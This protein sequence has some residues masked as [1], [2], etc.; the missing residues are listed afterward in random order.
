MLLAVRLCHRCEL[1]SNVLARVRV[2]THGR[3]TPFVSH[4]FHYLF[5]H[6]FRFY[7][8]H[9]PLRLC[10]L[11]PFLTFRR[12]RCIVVCVALR[13]VCPFVFRYSLHEPILK[14]RKINVLSVAIRTLATV[15]GLTLS[16]TNPCTRPQTGHIDTVVVRQIALKN[17]QLSSSL[18]S[19]PCPSPNPLWRVPA[20]KA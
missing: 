11:S 17:A 20:T 16:P 2:L 15:T 13:C 18:S 14:I 7:L 4:I 19:T 3:I 12:R 9:R 10:V 1:D 8:L 6:P 5:S